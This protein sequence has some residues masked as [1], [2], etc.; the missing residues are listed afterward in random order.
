MLMFKRILLRLRDMKTIATLISE[1]DKQANLSGEEEPGVE[2]FV[3]SAIELPDGSA[4]RVL[5]QIGTDPEEFKEAIKKQYIEALN[6][7]GISHKCIE[8]D[9]E[10]I[11]SKTL[12]HNSKPSG[13]ALMKALHAFKKEEKDSPL[14]G[15]HVLVVAASMKHSVAGRAFKIMGIDT[16]I[17][18]DAAK[19]ELASIQ[20]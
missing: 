18:T 13:Q 3:L 15:M 14:L 17:L 4:K 20:Y 10:P 12:L 6:S 9:P 8:D 7:A 5:K 2:H 1:A 19:D 16:K 11:E